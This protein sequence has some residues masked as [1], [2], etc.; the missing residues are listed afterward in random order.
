MTAQ[1]EKFF[2]CILTFEF[3][4]TKRSLYLESNFEIKVR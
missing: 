4:S 1:I 3:L 2:K